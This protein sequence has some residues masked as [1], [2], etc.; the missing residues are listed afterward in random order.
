MASSL[1]D[2]GKKNRVYIMEYT[3]NGL[4]NYVFELIRRIAATPSVSWIVKMK[5]KVLLGAQLAYTACWEGA[6]ALYTR[7]DTLV[8]YLDPKL[9]ARDRAVDLLGRMTLE[10][11]VGQLGGIRRVAS[12]SNGKLTFNQTSFEHIRETQNGQIGRRALQLI[13]SHIS[14]TNTYT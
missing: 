10:E 5:A 14:P 9:P 11:K 2:Q 3:F 4:G 1:I 8:P 12:R 7:D 13:H 6:M